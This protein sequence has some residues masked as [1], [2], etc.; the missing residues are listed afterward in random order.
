MGTRSK[1]IFTDGKQLIDIYKHWDGYLTGTFP[2]I[3]EI[4]FEAKTLQDCLELFADKYGPESKDKIMSI[5]PIPYSIDFYENDSYQC[6][7]DLEYVYIINITDK[8]VDAFS[9]HGCEYGIIAQKH[10]SI[11]EEVF[12]LR[13]EYQSECF[14]ELSEIV[15][16]LKEIGYSFNTSSYP[17]VTMALKKYKKE[18]RD[19][20][21]EDYENKNE[22]LCLN[23]T[24]NNIKK[25]FN[26]ISSKTLQELILNLDKE[27]S[28]K[29]SK[30]TKSKYSYFIT[31]SEWTKQ[32]EDIFGIYNTNVQSIRYLSSYLGLDIEIKEERK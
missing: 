30:I 9:G 20:E 28:L 24:L 10:I 15:N 17:I 31:V 2:L 14:K 7:G 11:E 25:M 12:N 19:K 13:E 32:A 8:T 27:N 22:L 4:V 29:I 23:Q 26:G 3:Y 5:T 18:Q 16:A 21:S 6:H 1:L